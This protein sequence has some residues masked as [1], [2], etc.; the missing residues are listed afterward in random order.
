MYV[1]M[2]FTII[3]LQCNGPGENLVQEDTVVIGLL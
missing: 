2:A 3:I 1:D